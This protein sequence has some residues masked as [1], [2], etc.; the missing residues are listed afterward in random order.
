MSRKK[1][2]RKQGSA[3][4]AKPKLSKHELESVEKR[5]RKKKGKKPGN[6]QIEGNEQKIRKLAG[7]GE[8]D[9]RLGNKT[10]IILG[11]SSSVVKKVL[12]NDLKTPVLGKSSVLLLDKENEIYEIENDEKLLLINTKQEDKSVLTSDEVDYYNLKMDRYHELQNE[13]GVVE[14]NEPNETV[15]NNSNSEDDLW[16]R[17][18]NPDFTEY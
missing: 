13:I 4:R 16:D 11:K 9:S 18:D 5:V 17:L 7:Q 3:P 15:K 8:K 6:K 1:S 10:P 12:I 14:K 2:S